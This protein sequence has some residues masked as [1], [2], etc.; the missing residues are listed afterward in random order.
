M[1]T[2]R[3]LSRPEL[4]NAGSAVALLLLQ[5]LAGSGHRARGE[6]LPCHPSPL[7]VCALGCHPHAPVHPEL[8][9]GRGRGGSRRDAPQG[10]R[11]DSGWPPSVPPHH[12]LQKCQRVCPELGLRG[13]S[14]LAPP[15]ASGQPAALGAPL[16]ARLS[17]SR[18]L[19]APTPSEPRTSV[20]TLSSPA[21]SSGPSTRALTDEWRPVQ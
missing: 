11:R 14:P 4:P 10:Q 19:E 18:V 6:V 2:T 13:L 1:E 17:G 20:L 9:T 21:A 7:W 16:L 5:P 3:A 15:V 12:P 8:P